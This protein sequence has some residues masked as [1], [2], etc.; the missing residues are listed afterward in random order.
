MSESGVRKA[1]NGG[2][3]PTWQWATKVLIGVVLLV[4]GAFTSRA[5]DRSERV[6]ALANDNKARISAIE[7]TL[8]GMAKDFKRVADA[9]PTKP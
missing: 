7:S 8:I 9:L 5:L 2:Y 6:E 3:G 1:L 4:I